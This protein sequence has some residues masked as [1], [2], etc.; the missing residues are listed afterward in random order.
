MTRQI[1]V[2]VPTIDEPEE[3]R[4]C[5]DCLNNQYYDNFD[6]LIVD[7]GTGV[8]RDVVNDFS[9]RL[10]VEMLSMR[11]NGLPRARNKAVTYIDET[12]VVAFCDPDARPVSD[13]LGALAVEY[14]DGVGAVGGPVLE[15][16]D[17]LQ[18]RETVGRIQPNGEIV[19]NF[20]A[21]DR[22]LVHHL[23]GTNMSFDVDLLRELGGFDPA[24]EGTAHYEDTDA[25]YK[26]HRAGYDVVYT[27]EA[28]LEHYHPESER[29]LKAYHHYRL[30]NWPIL[31]EKTSPTLLDRVSF[32]TR[33]LMR[34]G[35]YRLRL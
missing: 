35:Y 22:C 31:F 12:D 5:L 23:R 20:D 21:D 2:V 14:T 25:T 7:S 30:A 10:A 19:S 18:D 16:G 28:V 26:V 9:D 27:P 24:Y 32:Y 29:D 3:L 6:V 34:A 4:G 1:T 8:N 13:W 17:S 15:P 33:L 11:R